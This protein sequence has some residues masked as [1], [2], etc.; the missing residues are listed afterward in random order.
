MKIVGVGLYGCCLNQQRQMMSRLASLHRGVVRAL[1]IYV[2]SMSDADVCRGILAG[3]RD[4]AAVIRRVTLCSVQLGVANI[5]KPQP[6]DVLSV[7]DDFLV[8]TTDVVIDTES[9]IR[10][11][12]QG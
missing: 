12:C 10:C 4:L 7:L 9:V 5:T 11:S 6:D 3:C 8:Q 2:R 1:R